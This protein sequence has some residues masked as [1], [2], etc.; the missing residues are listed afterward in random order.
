M[1]FVYGLRAP[2]EAEYFYIGSTKHPP[3]VR[4]KGHIDALR[5]ETNK[6]RRFASRARRI[7][8]NNI[9]IETIEEC[10]ASDRF[11][12]EYA[13]IR[14]A[15]KRGVHL[16]NLIVAPRD[17]ELARAHSEY[18]DFILTPRH[19]AVMVDA[20]EFGLPHT[21]S[22]T[23]DMLASFIE[24]SSRY[25]IVERTAEFLELVQEVMDGHYDRDEANRQTE[26]LRQRVSDVL[27]CV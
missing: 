9:L 18:D 25:L 27:E 3:H 22:A 11:D 15:L 26:D 16:T 2:D 4:L 1:A 24:E 7:G 10:S 21:G 20:V 5:R 12:R 6:N 14:D 13:I 19:I 8:F 17:F 23:H